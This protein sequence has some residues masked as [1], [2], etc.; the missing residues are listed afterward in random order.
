M[1]KTNII[2]VSLVFVAALAGNAFCAKVQ[3]NI[4]ELKTGVL[5]SFADEDLK[6]INEVLTEKEQG[7]VDPSFERII[8]KLAKVKRAFPNSAGSIS[9]ILEDIR[10]IMS[11]IE[12]GGTG[13]FMS[14]N[15]I[16][17]VEKL[18]SDLAKLKNQDII[19]FNAT[20]GVIDTKYNVKGKSY[21]ISD[22]YDEADRFLP[23]MVQIRDI[24]GLVYSMKANALDD[25]SNR[26]SELKKEYPAAQKDIAFVTDNVTYMVLGLD[27]VLTY[28]SVFDAQNFENTL[29]NLE[30]ILSSLKESNPHVYD[31]VY[32]IIN[33][34][35]N[36]KT[37]GSYSISTIVFKV[38]EIFKDAGLPSTTAV[39]DPKK[40]LISMDAYSPLYK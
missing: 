27:K 28:K 40:I 32:S 25:V 19:A 6:A 21:S 26:L 16:T 34:E 24:G 2:I 3:D 30:S 36:T 20:R 22:F 38:N 17:P 9:A 7:Q 29:E 4:K 33:R 12:F 15:L 37:K 18:S 5:A 31:I 10:D 39:Y 13:E 8:L 1:K 11:R 14:Q 35:Y 23:G